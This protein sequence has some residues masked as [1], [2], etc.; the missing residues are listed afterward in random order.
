VTGF[1]SATRDISERKHAQEALQLSE[2]K[3]SKAFWS[4]P[5]AMCIT[6][7]NRGHFIDVNQSFLELSGCSREEIIGRTAND[8]SLWRSA[9]DRK[10]FYE[11]LSKTGRFQNIEVVARRKNGELRYVLLSAEIINLDTDPCVITTVKDITEATQS[12]EKIFF[13]ASLL[14]QVRNSVVVTD[15]STK[16]IYWNKYAETLYGWTAEETVGK[17]FEDVFGKSPGRQEFVRIVMEK[18]YWEGEKIVPRKDGSHFSCYCVITQLKDSQGSIIGIIRVGNDITERKRLEEDLRHAQKMDAIGRL[19]GG[20][21]HDY[22]NILAVIRGSADILHKRLDGESD[23][24]KQVSRIKVSTSRAAELT[25]K[26]L[27]FSRPKTIR[28][29]AIDVN[30]C[31][32]DVLAIADHTIDKRIR[33]VKELMPELPLI[34][35]DESQIELLLLN[36]IINACDAMLPILDEERERV[37][38][39]CTFVELIDPAFAEQ[40]RIDPNKLY[41]HLTVSDTGIG[42]PEEIR[43]KI[44]EPFFTTKEIDRGTGLGLAIV[45]GSVKGHNGAIDVE[46]VPGEGTT[47]HIYFPVIE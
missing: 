5:E 28:T 17:N 46:S 34:M 6:S 15:L 19:T 38:R 10:R 47:F 22:N 36:L 3:F 9:D 2:E 30:A 44:F 23:L 4:S 33:L 39:F 26:L 29:T 8:F 20:V 7:L 11:R 43:E 21:A 12:Q 40:N 31:V 25:R 16:I 1:L 18:G 27:T 32:E 41:I 14:D 35:G 45:Y 37:L 24:I 13:Q 42:I